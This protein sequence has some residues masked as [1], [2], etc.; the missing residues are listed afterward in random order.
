MSKKDDNEEKSM[1][2]KYVITTYREQLKMAKDEI[3]PYKINID[4]ERN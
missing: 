3:K 2:L 4:Y 1:F